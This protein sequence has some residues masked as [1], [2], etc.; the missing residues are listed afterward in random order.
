M[1]DIDEA[2]ARVRAE[3]P[4][5]GG[6]R[7]DVLATHRWPTNAHLIADVARLGYLD[8]HVLD[9]TY[10]EG[11]FWTVWRPER[12]TTMDKYKPADVQGDFVFPPFDDLTFDSVVFDPPYKLSGTPALGQFDDRYGIDKPMSYADRMELILDG[13]YACSH[14][15]R[16]Y[17]LVKCQDQVVSGKV[18]W[19]TDEITRDL[20]YTGWWRK[21]DRF[22]FIYTP[23]PQ[24]G[25]QVHARRNTSQLLVFE[26]R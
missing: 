17:L 26:R 12:L 21:V 19:Q 13:V 3:E 24:R 6:G 15:A 18:T 23:R 5:L 1:V 25:R 11:N 10:G 14:L 20:T 22:D 9:A 2:W 7:P 8:G 4:L 16:K